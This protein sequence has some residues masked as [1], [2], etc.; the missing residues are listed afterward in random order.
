MDVL[1]YL[2]ENFQYL[3]IF[4][5]LML[6]IIA[7]PLPDEI[8]MGTLGVMTNHSLNLYY[9]YF[10]ALAGSIAGITI[11]YFIGSWLGYPFLIKYGNRF[12]ITRRRLRI[13]QLLFR[14][15][16]NFLLTIAYF[17]PGVRHMTAY[18]AGI[19]KMSFPKF[20]LYA[21]SGA[22][23]WCATFIGLGHFLG[24]KWEVVWNVIHQYGFYALLVLVPILIVFVW[25]LWK[26]NK[27]FL[28]RL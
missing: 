17:I 16:G 9:T 3:G 18:L 28:Q 10:S 22:V 20:A 7:L 12:F 19:S 24:K 26:K 23:I 5:F 13:T 15:H 8:A 1:N 11:S 25:Y 6:G 4:I 27:S 2:L 21:Y 14:K